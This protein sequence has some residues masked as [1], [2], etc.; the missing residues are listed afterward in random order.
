MKKKTLI[1]VIPLLLAAGAHA[2]SD[3]NPWDSDVVE[4]Y[5]SKGSEI[6]KISNIENDSRWYATVRLKGNALY[7]QGSSKPDVESG[8]LQGNL[9]LSGKTMLFSDTGFVG[10][11]WLKV[12]E[13]YRNVDGETVNN[14]EGDLEDNVRWEQFRFGLE[15]DKYGALMLAKHTATWAFF[16]NDIGYQGL[17]DTQG[18]AGGKNSDKIIYKNQFDNNLFLNASYDTQS[19]I[20]GADLGYQTADIYAYA[21]DSYGIYLSAHNGQPMLENGYGNYIFGNSN[22]NGKVN[23]D[24][25][26]NRDSTSNL[27]YSLTGYTQV[28]M[29]HKL[30]ANISYSDMA[31]DEDADLIEDQGY[32][33]AGLGLSVTASYQMIPEGFSGLSPVV[34][35]SQDE[36]GTT[37]APELQYFFKPYMRV[38]A[39]HVFNSG[40]QD[41]TAV[42]FQLDF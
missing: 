7:A 39:V 11:F 23:S 42:E 29:R 24:T 38:W 32:A 10:D 3:T 14:F 12:Q 19:Y 31:D 2:K 1:L 5:L 26:L 30:A 33:T 16:A 9:R 8:Y 18:D 35:L 21:P 40:G 36:F 15:S 25:G 4:N 17:Y 41:V 22:P 34:T 27:T 20:M 6:T 28:A 13:N 37:F